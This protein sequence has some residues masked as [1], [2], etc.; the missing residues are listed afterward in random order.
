MEPDYEPIAICSTVRQL[1]RM[2]SFVTV[3]QHRDYRESWCRV[4]GLAVGLAV[5][6]WS[7]CVLVVDSATMS[8]YISPANKLFQHLDTLAAIKRGERPAPVN[9]EIFLSNRCSHG[10]NWCAYAHTHTRGPLAGKVA[11]PVGAINS[12]DL[13]DLDLA[14]HILRQL[15]SEGVKSVTWSGGGE[16]TLH[17]YFM[18]ITASA[19]LLGL[20][21]GI[22]THGGHIDED[23]ARM[24][25]QLFKW[26]Y[27]SLD[28]CTADAFKASKGVNRFD[29]VLDGIRRLVAAPGDAAIGIGFLLHPGNFREIYHMVKLGRDLGVDYVQFRPTVRYQQDAPGELAEDTAW[30]TEAILRLGQYAHDS[31]VVADIERFKMY[32]DWQGHGYSTCH[33]SALQT[34][35]SPNGMMWRCTNKTEHPDALLG[36]LSVESFAD[37]WARSGG[38]CAVD[39]K[40]RTMCIGHLKNAT[41]SA[42]FAETPHTNFI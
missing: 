5:A 36:D 28:E 33:W 26:V 20:D 19:M 25:K 21:Q 29:A 34:V 16:P 2:G 17:P 35:I 22:Y 41:L 18:G 37:V 31:F 8:Q 24:L 39:G 12:G 3:G 9:V 27:V 14:H 38:A 15:S 10:C 30:V 32:R 23:R 1:A 42:V 4:V 13:M 7:M 6:D 40:C 11:R